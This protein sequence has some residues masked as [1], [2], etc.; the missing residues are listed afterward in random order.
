MAN[1]PNPVVIDEAFPP[2]DG[3]AVVYRAAVNQWEACPAAGTRIVT[4]IANYIA[5]SGDIVLADATA[6]NIQVTIPHLQAV[7][8]VKQIDDSG[9]YITLVL[10]NSGTIDGQ[11]NAMI[12]QQYLSLH[13]ATDGTNGWLI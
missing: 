9:N 12:T 5:S 1:F 4:V 6:G 11:P 7:V 13:I 2:Q 3:Y 8:D 10:D